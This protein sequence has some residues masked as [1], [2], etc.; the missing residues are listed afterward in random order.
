M[1]VAQLQIFA[2][3]TSEGQQGE[4]P[5]GFLKTCCLW[6]QVLCGVFMG[7]VGRHVMCS[8]APSTDQEVRWNVCVFLLITLK[9]AQ[10]TF[11]EEVTYICRLTLY[12]F[13][14]SVFS[15]SLKWCWQ[16][17]PKVLCSFVYKRHRHFYLVPKYLF[18]T[19]FYIPCIKVT[20][21]WWPGGI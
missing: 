6:Q 8:R 15:L 4:S 12:Y 3:G 20:K 9:K 13:L 17:R 7:S 1:L 10:E 5:P 11:L 18:L 21:V 14:R 16:R 2:Q 19:H